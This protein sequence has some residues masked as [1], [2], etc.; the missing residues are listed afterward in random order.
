MNDGTHNHI[1]V[2]AVEI[3]AIAVIAVVAVI[4]TGLSRTVLCGLR[5]WVSGFV[6]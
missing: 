6:D 1:I 5:A 3:A 4:G 2:E